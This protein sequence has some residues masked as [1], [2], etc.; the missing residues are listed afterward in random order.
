M[1]FEVAGGKELVLTYVRHKDGIIWCLFCHS[2]HNLTH[3]Q[4][5]LLRMDGRLDDLH[6]L[7]LIQGL[8]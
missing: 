2:I 7:L 8:E 4:R 1:V 3:Q 5:S 6:T